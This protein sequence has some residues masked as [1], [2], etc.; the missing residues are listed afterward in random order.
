MSIELIGHVGVDS[1]QLL[2]C[3]PCYLDS[4]WEKEE[5]EDIRIYKNTKT[6]KTVQYRV[7]FDHYETIIP[8]YGM[9]MNE[10]NATGEWE[11]VET[12]LAKKNFS[13]N[14]CC[15]VTLSDNGVGQLKY[16]MGHP[17]VGVAFR[18]A[19]GDGYYPVYAKYSEDGTLKS[20][21]VVFWEDDHDEDDE[22]DDFKTFNE[23]PYGQD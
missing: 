23:A 16:K 21:E 10:L 5:F 18:T 12:P 1:G 3:D 20:V 6:G 7:H 4:E 19:F 8:E 13:Y 14:A 11:P 2:L 9:T 17:G 15:D 22:I